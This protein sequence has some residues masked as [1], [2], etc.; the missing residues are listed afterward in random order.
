M[1]EEPQALGQGQPDFQASQVDLLET[2]GRQP[3]QGRRGHGEQERPEPV[4]WPSTRMPSMKTRWRAAAARLGIDQGQ[5]GEDHEDQGDPGSREPAYQAAEG[6]GTAATLRE[7]GPELERECDLAVTFAE[8]VEA[9]CPTSAGRVVEVRPPTIEPLDD[10]EVIQLPEDDEWRP[11]ID[12][13]FGGFPEGLDFQSVPLGG[14]LDEERIAAVS[15]DATLI[16]QDVQ[17]HVAPVIFQDDPESGGA[18]FGGLHLEDGRR[19][20]RAVPPGF[21]VCHASGVRS[22]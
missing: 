16:A 21:C 9:H 3:H 1:P 10:E 19:L 2:R 7:L 15:G 12:E 8:F 20:D 22:G 13:P 11:A 5:A 6:A 17:G 4:K 14:I 18:A